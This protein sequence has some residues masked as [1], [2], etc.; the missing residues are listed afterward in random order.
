MLLTSFLVGDKKTF[1]FYTVN[2]IE[3]DNLAV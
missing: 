1:L 3:A 2:I